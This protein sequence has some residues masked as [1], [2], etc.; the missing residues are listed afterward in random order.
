MTRWMLPPDSDASD[1][2][3]VGAAQPAGLVALV[4][5]R[6]RTLAQSMPEALADLARARRGRRG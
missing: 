4:G 5:T 6:L 3:A 1:A 2:V